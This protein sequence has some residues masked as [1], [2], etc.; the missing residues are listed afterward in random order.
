MSRRSKD[1]PR[2]W[3]DYAAALRGYRVALGRTIE[4]VASLAGLSDRAELWTVTEYGR[5]RVRLFS[6]E[7]SAWEARN[8]QA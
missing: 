6:G 4:Q 7:E 2:E 1:V 5:R 8:R 3:V